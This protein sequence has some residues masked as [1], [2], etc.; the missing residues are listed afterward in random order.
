MKPRKKT[1][2]LELFKE[3][4]D[5]RPHV[6]TVCDAR[7]PMFT[8]RFFAHILGKGTEPAAR[9]DPDNIDIMCYPCHYRYDHETNRAA[10]DP[11]YDWVFD[12]KIE[13]R[14]KYNNNGT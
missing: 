2:E 9:L 4:W 10:G 3:I 7:L 14:A 5:K 6:C 12:K 8:V 1:G 13:I 11:R